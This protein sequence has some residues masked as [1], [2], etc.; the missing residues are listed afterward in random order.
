MTGTPPRPDDTAQH[1]AAA[2]L[3]AQ[4]PGW[5]VI[6]VPRKQQFQARHSAAG[7]TDSP[8]TGATLQELAAGMARVRPRAQP[9]A[10]ETR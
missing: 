7:W 6:W 5:V 9:A 8:V 3:S 10:G 1:G 2:R 4:R